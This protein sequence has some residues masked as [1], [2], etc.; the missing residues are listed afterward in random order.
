MTSTAK[1][2]TSHR[3]RS[4]LGKILAGAI[5]AIGLVAA[6]NAFAD[7]VDLKVVDRETGRPLQVW[8]Q[9][10]RL[11]VAG[12]PGS[13]YSLR[14]TNNTESRVL[15]V[16]SVDGVN[17]LSGETAGY[18]QRGYI[19]K[20]HQTFDLTG[21][22]KSTTEVAAFTFAPLP[23]SYAALTG[24]PADVGVIGMAVFKERPPAPPPPVAPPPSSSS[25]T[26]DFSRRYQ[27]DAASAA[28]P[29]RA[30][31]PAPVPP[32]VAAGRGGPPPLPIPPAPPPPP[33]AMRAP[34]PPA[35]APSAGFATAEPRDEKLGTAHGAIEWSVSN[36]EPFERAT[37]YPQFVWQIEYDSYDN[38]VA[39]GVIP[40]VVP[41]RLSP[42]AFPSRP[43][44][45]GFVPDPPSP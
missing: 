17:I 13:R 9:D 4:V 18:D 8:R 22:R 7:P 40:P 30:P 38:L 39:S 34:P 19:F 25:R 32:P 16:L 26:E 27:S 45:A 37:P 6:A 35:A 44:G 20:P 12:Q 33:P 36:V 3:R 24:R 41:L 42:Q 31:S 2:K 43:N 1:L 11:Y 23:K 29:L 15:V 14:V 10:G 28:A 5:A 21:W